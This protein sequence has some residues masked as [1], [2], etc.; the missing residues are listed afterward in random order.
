MLCVDG[1]PT[2]A[3]TLQVKVE[4]CWN[5]M[6]NQTPSISNFYDLRNWEDPNCS[7]ALQHNEHEH[8]LQPAKHAKLSRHTPSGFCFTRYPC[9]V[10]FFE[11]EGHGP[12]SLSWRKRNFIA[13]NIT[14]D[15]KRWLNQSENQV[16]YATPRL[17]E[18]FGT[19]KQKVRAAPGPQ[20]LRGPCS[21]E[22]HLWILP[23]LP[24][25][26]RNI[27]KQWLVIFD[28]CVHV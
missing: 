10:F 13:S 5:F 1:K 21:V 3:T 18:P 26:S 8:F 24:S 16:P 7:L 22:F 9:N 4:S 20:P 19:T 12:D 17:D 28:P 23:K 11:L 2:Q 25:T 6:E 14:A 27:V 15:C